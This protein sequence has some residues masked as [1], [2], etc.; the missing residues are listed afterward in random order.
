M[1]Y[2]TL[3]NGHNKTPGSESQGQRG[4]S[5]GMVTFAYWY[6]F[7]LSDLLLTSKCTCPIVQEQII[8]KALSSI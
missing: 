5:G 4:S 2:G 3:S 8:A 6:K 1:Q 7:Y